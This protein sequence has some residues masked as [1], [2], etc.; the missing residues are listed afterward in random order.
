VRIGHPGVDIAEYEI[1]NDPNGVTGYIEPACEQ[2][3]WILWFTN[4]GEAIFHRRRADTGAVLD[5]PIKVSPSNLAE[6]K[7]RR[8]LTS[9]KLT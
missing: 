3:A 7:P 4:K 1:T 2:P 9:N 5:D 8:K 6:V